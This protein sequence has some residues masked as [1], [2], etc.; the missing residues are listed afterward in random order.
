MRPA[1][2]LVVVLIGCVAL[3]VAPTAANEPPKRAETSPADSR[4]DRIAELERR[5]A[6]LTRE[7]E[8]FKHL[9]TQAETDKQLAERQVKR[10]RE[11]LERRPTRLVPPAIPRLRSPPD[12]VP[13]NWSPRQF[14]GITY[15][16]VPL[17]QRQGTDGPRQT[18][19]T[20]E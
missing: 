1:R 12:T 8:K 9:W 7:N 13:P 14:N 16:I 19:P 3:L 6:E 15:Y 5:V 20:P 10:L 2:L 4:A 11:Q 18:R 17:G